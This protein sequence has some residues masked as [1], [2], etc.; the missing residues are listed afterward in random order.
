[1][2]GPD[3]GGLKA[4]QISRD[5]G[6]TA[7]PATAEQPVRPILP[8]QPSLTVNRIV[9]FVGFPRE[10]P[11]YT[12]VYRVRSFTWCFVLCPPSCDCFFLYYLDP[13]DPAACGLQAGFG[14]AAHGVAALTPA[15]APFT[16][17]RNPS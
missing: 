12:G 8:G 7:G 3:S 9:R 10:G 11:R 6:S 16:V 1:M 17:S 5:S 14:I 2:T 4:D 13:L 15:D